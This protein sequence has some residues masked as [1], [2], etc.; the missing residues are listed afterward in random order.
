MSLFW[1]WYFLYLSHSDIY[2]CFISSTAFSIPVSNR[3]GSTGW[4]IWWGCDSWVCRGGNMRSDSP[5]SSA[6]G[7]RLGLFLPPLQL[8]SFWPHR[9]WCFLRVCRAPQGQWQLNLQHRRRFPSVW[10]SGWGKAVP[11]LE[12]R[13]RAKS[14]RANDVEESM[15]VVKAKWMQRGQNKN[16]INSQ[17]VD[18]FLSHLARRKTQTIRRKLGNEH[19]NCIHSCFS[20]K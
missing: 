14:R 4:G 15:E 18:S 13:W 20:P 11:L 12:W 1:L 7:W 9:P 16:S 19:V 2:N 17:H 8:H 3:S 10:Q 6:G 5:I